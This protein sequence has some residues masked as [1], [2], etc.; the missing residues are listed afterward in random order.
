M[1]KTANFVFHYFNTQTLPR[2]ALFSK[3]HT[4]SWYMHKCYFIHAHEKSK[5]FPA[6]QCRGQT[7]EFHENHF[8]THTKAQQHY[9]Q[10]FYAKFLANWRIY[11]ESTDRNSLMPL[12]KM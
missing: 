8:M 3:W 4:V 10:M 12:S 2:W 7:Y 5:A 11:L 9:V 1:N 6:L